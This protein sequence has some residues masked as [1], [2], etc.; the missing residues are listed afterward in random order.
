MNEKKN[1]FIMKNEKFYGTE[2]KGYCPFE[3]AAGA[4]GRWGLGLG[5]GRA[6]VRQAVTDL[7]SR[8]SSRAALRQLAPRMFLSKP[9]TSL[10]C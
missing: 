10:A 6:G 7:V 1:H 2:P 8:L 3:Q 5:A 4:L 9:S